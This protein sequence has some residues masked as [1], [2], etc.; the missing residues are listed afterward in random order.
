[1]C[2]VVLC[3]V[4]SNC[5]VVCWVVPPCNVVGWVPVVYDMC[6]CYVLH[7]VL[8]RNDG[9]CVAAV[10]RCTL[11]W[12]VSRCGVLWCGLIPHA[13]LN[14]W[15]GVA[16]MCGFVPVVVDVVCCLFTQTC[17]CTYCVCATPR[18]GRRTCPP[19]V[20]WCYSQGR[21]SG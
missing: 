19:L 9:L 11:P 16:M 15:C 21:C 12:S 17:H 8:H 10:C 13:L 4:A 3:G 1:M 5:V 18:F 20:S 7:H 6:L 2:L 14:V